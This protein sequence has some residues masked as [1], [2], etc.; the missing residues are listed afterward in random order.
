MIPCESTVNH[1]LKKI[2]TPFT[3]RKAI[4]SQ[5]GAQLVPNQLDLLLREVQTLGPGRRR[6]HSSSNLKSGKS[7][8][9]VTWS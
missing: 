4:T 3:S 1:Q 9:V 5:N 7:T 8:T 2:L 6:N